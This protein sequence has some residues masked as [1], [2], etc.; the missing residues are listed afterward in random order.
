MTGEGSCS[1][2]VLE[3]GKAGRF[4]HGEREGSRPLGGTNRRIVPFVSDLRETRRESICFSRVNDININSRLEAIF[5]LILIAAGV[6]GVIV[7][8]M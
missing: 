4:S 1:W 3:T 6:A 7:G 8:L 2:E 5:E